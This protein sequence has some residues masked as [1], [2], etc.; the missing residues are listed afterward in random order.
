MEIEVR[1]E[2]TLH[3]AQMAQLV[4]HGAVMRDVAGS[5]PGWINNQD[6]KITEEKGLP[7]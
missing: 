5:N 4:E 3:R 6:L 2:A 1:F 7:L